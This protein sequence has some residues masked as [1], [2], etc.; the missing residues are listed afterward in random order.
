MI[1]G[2]WVLWSVQGAI[3]HI[4]TLRSILPANVLDHANVATRDNH[5]RSVVITKENRTKVRAFRMTGEF[6]GV[7]RSPR[8]EDWCPLGAF[9]HDYYSM[10]FHAIA[11]RD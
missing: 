8:Q 5:I 9:R 2:R 6:S 10:Q 3:H 11:H 4:V 1:D 7:I